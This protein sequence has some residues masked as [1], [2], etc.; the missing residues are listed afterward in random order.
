M[1]ADHCHNVT[2]DIRPKKRMRIRFT[3]RQAMPTDNSVNIPEEIIHDILLLLP[4][5][6]LLKCTAV[7]K[8][9]RSLIQSSAFIHT[10][11][12]QNDDA[13]LLLLQFSN[14]EERKRFYSLHWDRCPSFS[15]Y[16]KL[17]DPFVAYN[18]ISGRQE[19]NNQTTQMG[20]RNCKVKV[21]GT[22]NG[23]VCLQEGDI[24][25]LIWN[26][27]IRKFVVLPPPGVTFMG[28]ESHAFGYDP[29]TNDYK[30]FRSV[31]Y[32]KP[33]R[34]SRAVEIFSLARGCWKRLRN[35][36]VP[37]NFSP[38][39]FTSN[40]KPDALVN[41]ALHWIQTEGDD[42]FIV[43]FDL[44]TEL[45][46]KILMPKSALRRRTKRWTREAPVVKNVC[47]ASGYGD[48]LCLF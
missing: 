30:V 14:R 21:L 38:G 26:P 33:S 1:P 18:E 17:T 20:N 12:N 2:E 25:T 5:K 48:C 31:S 13:H 16:S 43:S 32:Y 22:C 28:S 36:V 39:N 40:D 7:C 10:H 23:L 8:S 45:F 6:Y 34:L 47:Y 11:L 29:L 15:E 3:C 42:K 24:A 4:I 35:A 19:D 41:G 9:W 37:A 44:S 46:G 27:S